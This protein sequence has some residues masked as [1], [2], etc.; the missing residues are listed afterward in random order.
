MRQQQQNEQIPEVLETLERAPQR[1][2]STLEGKRLEILYFS[3][4]M[5]VY[6]HYIKFSH[7]ERTKQS[8]QNILQ[9]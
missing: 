1:W 3:A 2:Q 9:K 8:D 7:M 4:Q 5:G 6:F